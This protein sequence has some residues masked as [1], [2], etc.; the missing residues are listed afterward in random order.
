[1]VASLVGLLSLTLWGCRKQEAPKS[2]QPVVI[3]VSIDTLRADH[4]GSYGYERDTSPF[5][6]QLASNGA[7]FEFARSASPWTLPAH[8]T[9]L[10]GQLPASHH[11]VDDS[12]SLSLQTP[13]LAEVMQSKGWA[14]G[15]FVSTMYVSTLFGFH[16]GFDRFEDFDLLS[17][18]K[19]LSGTVNAE[20]VI[21]E[22]LAWFSEQNAEQPLFLFLHF[23]DVHYSY[24]PPAPYNEK[25]DRAPEEG[26]L[27]YRNY[28]HFKKAKVD[29][30][31][32]EHQIAQYD[33]EIAYV[34]D[35]L[36]RLNTEISAKRP[37]IRWVITAD[38]GEEFWERGSWGHAHTLYSEQL[39]IPLIVSGY[40]IPKVVVNSNW[41]GNH[42]VAPTIASWADAGDSLQAE[43][44]NLTPFM[45]E[46][47]QKDLPSRP[48]LAETSRFKT[49]RISLLEDGYRVEWDLKSNQVELFE[50]D[51]DLKEVHDL[52][53]KEPVIVQALQ[54]RMEELLGKPWSAQKDGVVLLEDAI[55]LKNGRK[56]S[57]IPVMSGESFQI[58]PYDAKVFFK[59]IE[60]E[61][62]GPWQLVGGDSVVLNALKVEA[63]G[64][65]KVELDEK[66]RQN[67]EKLGYIQKD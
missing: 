50:T 17:E 22:A 57:N 38:H 60:G 44:L 37:N 26:D 39:H 8:V 33:E 56:V 7:R 29:L 42:D 16:R 58:L 62:I 41:V 15:G 25:F 36:K 27:K 10:T 63:Q 12:V 34:D 21:D 49:N 6:D 2:E 43:G 51:Q 67:L 23:Y 53:E 40:D 30:A 35:Q 48:M 13:L 11:V 18:K 1:M 14:T 45:D 3:L 4:L 31:Q 52:A 66:T 32:Q 19:N 24:D 28:F 5:L 47:T 54:N 55:M 64:A 65:Q 59:E 9:M 20:N 46:K 61:K